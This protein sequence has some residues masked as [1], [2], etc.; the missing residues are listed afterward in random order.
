MFG[1]MKCIYLVDDICGI[2]W[3]CCLEILIV[4]WMF[5]LD[6]VLVCLL[7]WDFIVC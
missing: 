1:G 2:I 4:Y 6:Y 3:I 7:Y 5:F